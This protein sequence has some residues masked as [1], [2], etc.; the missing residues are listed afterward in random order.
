MFTFRKYTY[1]FDPHFSHFRK[2]ILSEFMT[3][4]ENEF[5]MDLE[6][7]E[8]AKKSLK[9][10]IPFAQNLFS[11]NQESNPFAFSFFLSLLLLFVILSSPLLLPPLPCLHHPHQESQVVGEAVV[12]V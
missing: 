5:L 12:A 9:V 4:Q 7:K 8:R 11:F 1:F 3:R 6:T 10:A 2:P